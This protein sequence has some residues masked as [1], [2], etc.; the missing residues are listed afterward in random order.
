MGLDISRAYLATLC[1]AKAVSLWGDRK[2][3]WKPT[4]E[5]I[6]SE[7]ER[8]RQTETHTEREILQKG[9]NL[10]FTQLFNSVSCPW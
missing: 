2:I 5:T 8:E 3:K 6:H 10:D 1:E 9:D 7:G 4:R